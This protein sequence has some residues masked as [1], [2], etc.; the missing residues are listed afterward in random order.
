MAH[1]NCRL[2]VGFTATLFAPLVGFVCSLWSELFAAFPQTCLWLFRN[3]VCGFA[4]DLFV[5]FPQIYL[6]VCRRF[7][8]GFPTDLFV[9]LPQICLRLFRTLESLTDWS[10][11]RWS[12]SSQPSQPSQPA[13]MRVAMGFRLWLCGFMLC[14]SIAPGLPPGLPP[15]FPAIAFDCPSILNCPAIAPRL[16]SKETA[17][18]QALP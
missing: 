5:G 8:C 13:Y 3:L 1:L 9:G 6:W 11:N 16:P 2:S 17:W 12:T 10:V 4:A 15:G 14:P 18:L 7:I